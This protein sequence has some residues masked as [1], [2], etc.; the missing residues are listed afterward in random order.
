ML[1][2]YITSSPDTPAGILIFLPGVE[3]IRQCIAAISS[4]VIEDEVDIYPLHANLTSED[5]RAVFKVSKKWKIIAATNVAE[6]SICRSYWSLV[7]LIGSDRRPS[8][9]MM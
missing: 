1:I 4:A 9:L 5:Q 7:P 3:E 2:K 6:A 8:L